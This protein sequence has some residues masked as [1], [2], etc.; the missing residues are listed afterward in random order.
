MPRVLHCIEWNEA[1]QTCTTEAWVEQPAEL[2]SYLPTVEQAQTVG[3]TMFT[4]LVI[5]AAMSLF[6][7][8]NST[9]EKE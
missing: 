1:T 9:S 8:S 7:P 3:A 5:V 2:V 6:L 4:A